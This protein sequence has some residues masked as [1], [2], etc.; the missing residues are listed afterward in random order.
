[1]SSV[2]EICPTAEDYS[3]PGEIESLV[4]AFESCALPREAWTHRAH[5]TVALWYLLRHDR[6]EAT[7]LIRDG[8]KRYNA[9][10]GIVTTRTSGYHETITLFYI[11]IVG[12]HLRESRADVSLVSLM[13]SL[14]RKY[15]ER[16]LP[17]EYYS[18]DRLMSWEA[19]SSWVEPDL[20]PLG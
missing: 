2:A 17:L 20:K 5:L 13:N 6:G 11:H 3:R 18:K 14:M 16:S 9:A 1:M 19:R 10:K 12:K 8:I 7:R 4:L 15:G